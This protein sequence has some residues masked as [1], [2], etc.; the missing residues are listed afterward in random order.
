MRKS[1][2]NM[3][4]GQL[5]PCRSSL[6]LGAGFCVIFFIA[7]LTGCHK[8]EE[9]EVPKGTIYYT[10]KMAPKPSPANSDNAASKKSP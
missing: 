5:A 9:E 8:A 6:V 7:G 10:G 4:F 1:L 3:P 2:V